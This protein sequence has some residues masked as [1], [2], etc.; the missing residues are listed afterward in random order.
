[1][2]VIFHLRCS[3]NALPIVLRADVVQ[4]YLHKALA[5]MC[6]RPDARGNLIANIPSRLSGSRLR[7]AS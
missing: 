4:R 7:D 6:N 3:E 5:D 2:P 1:M